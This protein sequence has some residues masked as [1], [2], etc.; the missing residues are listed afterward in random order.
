VAHR[1]PTKQLLAPVNQHALLQIIA[2]IDGA[3]ASE[4]ICAWATAPG[5]IGKIMQT[6][7]APIVSA[8]AP[9]P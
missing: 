8:D 3:F 6:F 1:C 7:C 5:G 2:V 4:H 9:A